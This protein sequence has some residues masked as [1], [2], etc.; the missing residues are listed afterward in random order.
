MSL[1]RSFQRFQNRNKRIPSVKSKVYFE[2][3]EP[4]LLL[5]SDP[6]IHGGVDPGPDT[7]LK[8]SVL[9]VGGEPSGRSA[10]AIEMESSDTVQK[11]TVFPAMEEPSL[12]VA[13]RTDISSYSAPLRALPALGSLIY[14]PPVSG[15]FEEVGEVDTYTIN[16]DGSQTLSLLMGPEDPSILGQI[17][18]LDPDGISLGSMNAGA[19]GEPVVLQTVPIPEG[20]NYTFRVASIEGTGAYEIEVFLNS[21]LEAEP[22]GGPTND[23]LATA[24]DLNASTIPLQGTADRLAVLG[25]TEGADDFYQFDLIAGQAATL[26]L[27]RTDGM[28][29]EAALSLELRD[30]AGVV[31][32]LGVDD[33]TNTDLAIRGLIAPAPGTYYARVSGETGRPYSLVIT[34]GAEFER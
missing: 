34:R 3:L 28:E 32:A 26:V 8:E 17:E 33:A 15:T 6:T 22:H 13:T 18:V 14:D 12:V 11:A 27:T 9:V 5:S 10:L 1:V 29:L 19:A 24:Q 30:A 16:L 7:L 23:T 2:P 31:L 4:R 20:G 25:S 21:A